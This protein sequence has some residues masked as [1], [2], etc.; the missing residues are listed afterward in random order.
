M[1]IDVL[2]TCQLDDLNR[3]CY[4]NKKDASIKTKGCPLRRDEVLVIMRLGYER[5]KQLK[6]VGREDGLQKLFF[7]H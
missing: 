1:T 7:H 3:T 5:G 4:S 6:D 2:L